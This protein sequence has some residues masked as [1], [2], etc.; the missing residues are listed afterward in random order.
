MTP[1]VG[2]VIIN[3]KDYAQRFLAD[4]RDSLRQLD[5]P[6][7]R[8]TV[9]LVDN[10]T[11]PES[12]AHLRREYPEAVVIPEVT[13]AGWGGGN[14]IGAARALADGCNDFVFA[15]M[16]VVVDPDWLR[17]LVEAAYSTS[18]IGIVQS[19]IL[20]H[21]APLQ[22]TSNSPEPKT[23]LRVFGSPMCNDRPKWCGIH[24]V[25]ADGIVRVN[26]VGN[27]FHFLG[28]GF[29]DGYGQP[30]SALTDSCIR[31]IGYASGASLYVKGDVFYRVG[32]CNPDFF[33][34]HDD[35]ELCLRA[36]LAGY[37]V[38]LAPASVIRHKYEFRRSVRQVEYMERN[39]LLV[40]LEFYRI[41][42][43]LLVAPALVFME[44]GVFLGAIIGGYASAKLRGWLYF[45]RLDNWSRIFR[46]RRRIQS[47]RIISDRVLLHDVAA[48]IDFQEVANPL[49]RYIANPSLRIYWLVARR[50]LWW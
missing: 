48:T 3:Y 22:P 29:C 14:N 26:S 23:L 49:L 34:Y 38:V 19:R 46:D 9:Y 7:D 12:I 43:L 6:A 20:L 47:L 18:Q 27:R 41:P 39:R 1:K 35:I 11:S 40:L 4:C 45:T 10:A 50:I 33:M 17:A 15:N 25:G 13:N 5:Y 24:P 21:P 30:V 44:I 37:R 42:T 31:D 8:F 28:F 2:I 16:D 32:Q 36:K